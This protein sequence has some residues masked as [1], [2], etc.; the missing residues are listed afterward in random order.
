MKFKGGEFSTGTTGNFQPE[1][2]MEQT[3]HGDDVFSSLWRGQRVYNTRVH[4][5]CLMECTRCASHNVKSFNAELAIHFP[6]PE[7]LSKPIVWV[8]P[9]LEVCL[10]CGSTNF[11]VPEEQL[12]LLLRGLASPHGG[13]EDAVGN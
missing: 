9:R 8:F 5:R 11:A 7:G 10:V 2:T 3:K 12:S 1:L 6:G 4:F 13:A